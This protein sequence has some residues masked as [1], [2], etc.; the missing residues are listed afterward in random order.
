MTSNQTVSAAGPGLKRVLTLPALIIYGII[1]VQPTAPMPLFG[2]AYDKANGHVVTLILIGM[3]AMLF[4]ALS[5][6]WMANAYPSAGSAYAYVSREIHPAPGY[7]TGWSMMF[8]YVMNP[9]ICV[10]WCS[11]ATVDLGVLP[12]VPVQAWFVAYALLFTG[13]NLRGI[14]A[15]ARTNAIIAAGLGV[16]IVLFFYAA[17]RHLVQNPPADAAALARPFY[18]PATFSWKTLSSGAALAVLT[19]IGFDGISTLSEEVHNPRRNV[20]LATVLVCLITGVLASL[21]VYTAQLVWLK[22]ASAFPSLE[23]A[24]AHVA[25]LVGGRALFVIVTGSLLVASIGSGMGAHLGAGRLLYGM[26]RDNA[27]PRKFFGVVNPR[28]RVPS[29]NIMLVGAIALVGAFVLDYDQRGYDLGAQLLNFGALFGFMG[30]NVSALIHYYVRGRDRRLRHLIAPVLGFLICLYLWV[31]LA[32]I[33]LM[34]GVCWLGLGILYGAWRTSWFRKPI[35]FARIG[36]D[37]DSPPAATAP[38]SVKQ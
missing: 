26:G 38:E 18:D 36:A 17:I 33:T 15:S 6:G 32:W 37:E 30:V 29:N 28:T 31:S 10:I 8:D 25:G 19:Y 9:V 13:L 3:V 12:G 21:E 24:F 27:I 5:Y 11:K 20:L 4:T 7:L 22:P 34:V 2:L 23:N 14:E 35:D 1:L 16:V